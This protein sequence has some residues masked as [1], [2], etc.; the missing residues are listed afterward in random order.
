MQNKQYKRIENYLKNKVI[1]KK[2]EKINKIDQ[3]VFKIMDNYLFNFIINSILFISFLISMWHTIQFGFGVFVSFE[4]YFSKLFEINFLT[5]LIV[6]LVFLFILS[7]SAI[8]PLMIYIIVVDNFLNNSCNKIYRQ[9]LTKEKLIDDILDLD[10]AKTRKDKLLKLFKE[11]SLMN[12]ELNLS[13]VGKI[14]LIQI[15]HEF[16]LNNIKKDEKSISL[17]EMEKEKIK[18]LKRKLEIQQAVW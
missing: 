10:I 5:T 13:D 17:T 16:E 18:T 15:E 7:L 12:Q 3:I 4:N 6:F 2:N 8:I 9:N 11:H 14:V 1:K